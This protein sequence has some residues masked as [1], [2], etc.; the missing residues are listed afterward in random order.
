MQGSSTQH[1]QASPRMQGHGCARDP[2]I[3]PNL[4]PFY[5]TSSN[6]LF[7]ISGYVPVSFWQTAIEPTKLFATNKA[8]R[9]A[10]NG[11]Y[12]TRSPRPLAQED[13]THA[14]GPWYH[15][16]HPGGPCTRAVMA[17]TWSHL[18]HG[19]TFKPRLAV[20]SQDVDRV[21]EKRLEDLPGG[22]L[23]IGMHPPCT[24]TGWWC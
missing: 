17:Q 10:F 4:H 1:H 11:M 5:A 12:G 18:Q 13:A 22:C 23:V 24:C 9:P 3:D 6:T 16:Y 21:N 15:S 19:R 8:A 20:Y 14:R 2:D 7:W